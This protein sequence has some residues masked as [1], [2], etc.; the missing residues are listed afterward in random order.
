MKHFALVLFSLLAP[1]LFA[2]LPVQGTPICQAQNCFFATVS[3]SIGSSGTSKLTIQQPSTG[4]KQVTFIAAVVQCAGQTFTVDQSQNGTAASATAGSAVALAP[5]SAAAVAKVF[6]ASNVGG[7]TAVAPTL[8]YTAG[9]ARV[10]DLSYLFMKASGTTNNYT[11]TVTN[12][13]GSS[14]TGGIS[15][16]WGE[17][18]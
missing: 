1:R 16:Y 13:G 3:G 12:T 8:S 10:I 2:Q 18:Q 9:D 14:C 17:K 4:G 5:N 7:G 11:V 15:I 6:T